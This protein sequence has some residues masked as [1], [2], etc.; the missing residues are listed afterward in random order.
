MG[1]MVWTGTYIDLKKYVESPGGITKV[2]YL[3]QW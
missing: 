3:V 2:H 1:S